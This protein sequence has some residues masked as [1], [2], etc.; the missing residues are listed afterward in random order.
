MPT[1]EYARSSFG[2]LLRGQRYRQQF[3]RSDVR[4]SIQV[5]VFTT[6]AAIITVRNDILLGWNSSVL[7]F[8]I[9]IR[10]VQTIVALW[11]L[12]VM[13]KGPSIRRYD[14]AQTAWVGSMTLLL[15]LMSHSRWIQGEVQGPILA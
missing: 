9:F 7:K 4:L 6:L 3:L 13:L 15:L 8:L 5:I 1:R 14:C 10:V 11:A 12:R 2:G